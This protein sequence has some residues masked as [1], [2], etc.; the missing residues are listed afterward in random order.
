MKVKAIYIAELGETF[1]IEEIAS[2]TDV[3]EIKN[4]QIN[5]SFQFSIYFKSG[6]CRTIRNHRTLPGQSMNVYTKEWLESIRKQFL[7]HIKLINAQETDKEQLKFPKYLVM[8]HNYPAAFV[9]NKKD[10]TD[11][12]SKEE[13][14]FIPIKIGDIS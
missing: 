5:S 14:E 13:L 7:K 6:L 1:F 12:D 9:I 8:Q 3:I 2:I 10:Y 11:Y 4:Y